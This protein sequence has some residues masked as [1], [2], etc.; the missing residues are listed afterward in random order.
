MFYDVTSITQ[1]KNPDLI[2][3]LCHKISTLDQPHMTLSGE[4]FD[5]VVEINLN[6]SP[7]KGVRT[8]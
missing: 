8:S 1:E 4:R 2:M 5:G 3:E 7:C 6:Y